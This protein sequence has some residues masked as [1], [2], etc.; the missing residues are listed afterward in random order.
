VTEGAKPCVGCGKGRD[1][2]LDHEAECPITYIGPQAHTRPL[3][4]SQ[5]E[6]R[7]EDLE[8]KLLSFAAMNLVLATIL[9]QRR[10]LDD[11]ELFSVVAAAKRIHE[12]G[13]PK[14]FE[15]LLRWAANKL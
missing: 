11:M 1:G 12:N 13:G 9:K 6:A 3:S 10:F 14:D 15:E 7:I 2:R 4:L 8:D 5:L